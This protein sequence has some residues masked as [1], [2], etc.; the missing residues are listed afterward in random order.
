M[1]DRWAVYH[2]RSYL[3]EVPL[4]TPTESHASLAHA[5]A[6]EKA[7][8]PEGPRGQGCGDA[9]RMVAGLG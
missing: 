8:G 3:A 1:A 5:S 6:H 2:R 7:P 4:G 9:G